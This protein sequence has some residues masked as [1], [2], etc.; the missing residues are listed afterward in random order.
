M[1][2]RLFIIL[3]VVFSEITYPQPLNDRVLM[4]IDNREVPAG[5]FIRMYKKTYETGDLSEFDQYLE[6]YIIFKLKVTDA[7]REGYDTTVSFKNELQGYREQIARNL[8]T[9]QKVRENILKKAYE[10]SLKEINAWHILISCPP[11]SSPEDTLA[12]WKKT[13]EVKARIDGGEPFE[14]VARSTSDDPSVKYNGGNLGYI[15]SFQMVPQFEDA[16]YGMK[17]GEISGPV[18]TPY[19]YHIIMV[20][21]IRPSQGR[22]KVA[23]IMRS[24]PPG[25][26]ES[27]A[28]AAEDTIKAVYRQL[29]AGASFSELA[30]KYSDHRESAVRGGE[31]NWFGAGEIAPE[32]AEASFALKKNGDISPPVRTMFGWHIIKRLDL[33]SPPPYEEARPQ[34]ESKIDGTWLNSMGVK[35]LVEKLKKEY[36]FSLNN[37]A[38]NWFINNTDT[39]ITKGYSKYDRKMIPAGL[40]YTFAGQKYSVSEFAKYIEN[41]TSPENNEAPESFVKNLLESCIT[42]HVLK[43]ENSILE[44]KYPDFRYL[45]K[46]FHDGILL[47]EISSKKVWD[48]INDTVLLKQFYDEHKH[49]FP[50]KR[51]FEGTI[52]AYKKVDKAGKFYPAFDRFSRYPDLDERLAKKFNTRNDTVILIHK[53]IWQEGDTTLP[54]NIEWKEGYYH[55][56]YSGFPAVVF[57]RKIMEPVPLPFDQI[58]GELITRFQNYLESEWIKQLKEKYTV[59]LDSNVLEEVKKNLKNE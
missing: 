29:L 6:Q 20:K 7:I 37:N 2:H 16:V 57:I 13:L 27:T 12:A 24:I 59:R 56:T 22:I 53:G 40:L 30:K 47:F 52:Y 46:E 32:F 8:L 23:H 58:E 33:K 4:V 17:K 39:L 14:Q 48:K 28:K 44:N 41:K 5:E 31:I 1:K 36:N 54:E 15:S 19:G 43:Y 49:E 25:A 11:G 35:S 9:D 50:G 18:R 42:S 55:T 51:A 34:L 21:E 3:S 26:S 45:V 38:F 10:R